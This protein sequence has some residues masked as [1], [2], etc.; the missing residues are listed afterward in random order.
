MQMTN[1]RR[2]DIRGA[3]AD[4]FLTQAQDAGKP[5]TPEDAMDAAHAIA[6]EFNREALTDLAALLHI[7]LQESACRS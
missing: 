5:L 2:L 6:F 7:V 4:L 1:G 3:M